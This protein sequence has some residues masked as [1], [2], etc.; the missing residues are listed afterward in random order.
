MSAALKIVAPGLHTTLQDLGRWGYQAVGVPVSGALDMTSL[1]LANRLVGNDE[2]TAALEILFQGPTIEVAAESV[3]VGL[4][5][6]DAQLELLGERPRLLGGWRSVVFRRGETFRVTPLADAACC[7]LA[8]EGG[9]AVLPCLNSL[10]TYVRG[11]I[12]GFSGRQLRAGDEVPLALDSPGDGL[13]QALRNPP[14][15]ARDQPIRIVL[16]P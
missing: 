13:E 12:G 4:A 2:G 6:G 16:G 14:A 7:Y 10:S 5:G 11:A 9:F 1:R 15:P 3:H 8:V